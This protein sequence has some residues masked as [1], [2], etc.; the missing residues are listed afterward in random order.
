MQLQI[1]DIRAN[2]KGLGNGNW[3]LARWEIHL[4]EIVG[5]FRACLAVAVL[6]TMLPKRKRRKLCYIPGGCREREWKREKASM[7]A[8]AVTAASYFICQI[9]VAEVN[10]A[11]VV[12]LFTK[13]LMMSIVD[14]EVTKL[15]GG[16][17]WRWR[18]L[19]CMLCS[20]SLHDRSIGSTLLHL[21]AMGREL[22]S[23]ADAN[24][25]ADC[26]CVRPLIVTGS[27]CCLL[28]FVWATAVGVAVLGLSLLCR[29][30]LQRRVANLLT[31][32]QNVIK[33]FAD[34]ALLSHNNNNHKCVYR[35]IKCHWQTAVLRNTLQ[36]KQSTA[37]NKCATFW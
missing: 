37:Q 7:S 25:E 30:L 20:K 9:H 8:W 35:I 4:A 12:V 29:P 5:Y 28:L 36:R 24:A 18:W 23:S 31:G 19:W 13:P 1:S 3:Q 32:T 11:F 14:D 21:A 15:A 34:C 33:C 6:I 27:V 2:R 10:F 22:T 17:Q 16:W 26:N